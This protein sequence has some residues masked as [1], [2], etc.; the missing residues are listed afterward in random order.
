MNNKHVWT[1]VIVLILCIMF[2][3]NRKVRLIILVKEQ[4]KVFRNDRLNR[5]SPWDYACF[6]LFPIVIAV[7]Y[8]LKLELII[9]NNLAELLTTVFSIVFTVLFGFSAIMISKMDSKNELEKQVAKETF[10]S[11][12]SS[13][14]LSLMAAILSIFLTQVKNTTCLK[15]MSVAVLTISLVTIMLLLLI[16]KRTFYLYINNGK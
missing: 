4:L 1:L 6:L 12:V 8:V 5:F 9:N 10:V 16:T 3:A 14:I 2:F 15:L 7:I 13:T 11:I